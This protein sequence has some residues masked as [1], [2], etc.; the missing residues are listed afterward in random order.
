MADRTASR[1]SDRGSAVVIAAIVM[2]AL[3]V[4][5][6][7]VVDLGVARQVRRSNQS[8]ADLAALAAG[9][10]LGADPFPDGPSACADAVEYLKA[11][12]KSWPVGLTVPCGSL[13][14][15][16]TAATPPVSVTDG[17]TGG[18]YSISITYPVSDAA[19]ADIGVSDPN[20]LRRNDGT[21]CERI[22]VE[23][24]RSFDSMFAGVVGRDSFSVDAAAVVR[25]VQASDR[26]VPSLW[27]LDP[28]GCPALDISGGSSVTVGTAT[29]P[30]LITIDSDASACSGNS[31]TI[32]AG[33]AGSTGWAI[34]DGLRQPAEISLFAMERLQSDCSTGNLNACDPSDVANLTI[35]PQPKRRGSRATR[36]PVD[37]VYNCKASYPDYHGIEIDSCSGISQPHID[38]LRAEVGTSGT[39]AGFNL[40][41]D[42]YGCNNP[43]TP[44]TG[45]DGN[46][47]VD[48]A[49]LKITSADVVFNGG[50]VIVDGGISLTGGSLSFN[51]SNPAASLPFGC[52][53]TLIGCVDDSSAAAAWVYMRDGNLSLTG[54][55]LNLHRTVI[56]QH[57]GFFTVSGGSPPV[58]TSP[59]EGPFAGLAAWSE[60]SSGKFKINGGASMVLEGTFFIPEAAPMS[61][62]GG[63]PVVPQMAQFVSYRLAV[64]GGAS[65]NLSPNPV[66]AIALPADAPLLIR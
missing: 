28:T 41:T 21:P 6:A 27:L 66:L 13:P 15:T 29:T 3:L 20:A 63:S 57:D 46:W 54:G 37:H 30:G 33:G 5:V 51:T 32:N 48:C 53:T 19:I 61:I 7:M 40:W 36:A 31:F 4:S 58:W 35:Y 1:W 52:Q 65:L 50:N 14:A 42:F 18:R 39:P 60:K 56:Y 26:R 49:S 12:L 17:G 38:Q 23:L 2:S 34:P 62:S 16:C 8:A 25:Q 9:E 10:A 11:N 55:A 64:S 44:P 59:I 47:H 22:S 24:E 43:A 45:V